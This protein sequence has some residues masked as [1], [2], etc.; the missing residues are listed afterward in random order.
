MDT[1]DNKNKIKGRFKINNEKTYVFF[2]NGKIFEEDKNG[3]LKEID[4]SKKQN[5][6]KIKK[7]IGRGYTDIER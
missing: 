3:N 4:I 1:S 7:D 5:I 2:T 6:E